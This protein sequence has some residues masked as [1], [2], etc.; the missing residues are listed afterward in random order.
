MMDSWYFC[1]ESSAI[2][3]MHRFHSKETY[4]MVDAIKK[5]SGFTWDDENGANVNVNTLPVWQDYR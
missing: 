1:E 4:L 5:L 2:L 3:Q